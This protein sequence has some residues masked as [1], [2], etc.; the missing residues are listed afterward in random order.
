[1]SSSVDFT[2]ITSSMA[3]RSFFVVDADMAFGK[4]V[5]HTNMEELSYDI[6]SFRGLY[7]YKCKTNGADVQKNPPKKIQRILVQNRHCVRNRCQYENGMVS[8]VFMLVK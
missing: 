7:L 1:M 6:F 2:P 3:L 5:E 8:R 4:L